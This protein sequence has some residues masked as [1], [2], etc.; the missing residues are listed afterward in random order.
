MKHTIFLLA[1]LVIFAKA[2][3]GQQLL[4][5][6]FSEREKIDTLIHGFL[7]WHKQ[8]NTQHTDNEDAYNVTK[9]G[10][11]DA[12]REKLDTAGVD[13]Y[14]KSLKRSP[15]LSDTFVNDLR[16][17]FFK[18]GEELDKRPKVD[19]LVAVH[20][21]DSD[22][23]LK[24]MESDVIFDNIEKG[25]MV[26]FKIIYNKAMAIFSISKTVQL[27]FT[28]TKID[29]RWLIDYVGYDNDKR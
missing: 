20:G 10:Y 19:D 25:R 3:F 6:K 14:L 16:L 2:S 22:W 18:I 28:F 12:T 7:K 23:I 9:G 4:E 11:P 24:T 29:N 26:D 8:I 21:L 1:I 5:K 27:L 13:L 15:Y 17:Y